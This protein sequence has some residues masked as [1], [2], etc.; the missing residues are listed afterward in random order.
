MD[1]NNNLYALKNNYAVKLDRAI[2]NAKSIIETT[3]KHLTIEY[4]KKMDFHVSGDELFKLREEYNKAI[5][6]LEKRL[7]KLNELYK[8]A[9]TLLKKCDSLPNEKLDSILNEIRTEYR[10]KLPKDTKYGIL[11][12]WK[13]ENNLYSDKDF[14]NMR[15]NINNLS[16]VMLKRIVEARKVQERLMELKKYDYIRDTIR[17]VDTSSSFDDMVYSIN[18]CDV[19]CQS[20]DRQLNESGYFLKYCNGVLGMEINDGVLNLETLQFIERH[21]SSLFSEN[22]IENLNDSKKYD[23]LMRRYMTEKDKILK[24]KSTYK[25]KKDRVKLALLS[26]IQDKYSDLQTIDGLNGK[27]TNVLGRID[28]NS[29]TYEL[30][31]ILDMI[32]N[33][34]LDGKK[35]FINSSYLYILY[36]YAA[37]NI[38]D[39]VPS[40]IYEVYSKYCEDSSTL[41][42]CFDVI[43]QEF[44]NC[45]FNTYYDL[46]TTVSGDYE[47]TARDNLYKFIDHIYQK[48]IGFGVKV[49][50]EL[51]KEYKD[52]DKLDIITLYDLYE[53]LRSNFTI[54][55]DEKEVN[56][57]REREK[58]IERALI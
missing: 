50:D 15:S 22:Y 54:F 37:N 55:N 53:R 45:K 2:D 24:V 16:T 12:K 28:K 41:D 14:K 11:K 36:F 10:E 47:D 8:K 48:Y 44:F 30:L 52:R 32:T 56:F 21:I 5:S 43:K 35:D 46:T 7:V 42:I 9:Q 51:L 4:S 13:E 17:K 26:E 38:I 39:K 6:K 1:S 34:E 27:D 31:E 49:D 40:I 58:N 23:D 19:L 20:V 25:K 29:S 33:K 18:E 3:I 57:V